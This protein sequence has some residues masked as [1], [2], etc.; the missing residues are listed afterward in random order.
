MKLLMMA[1]FLS[2]FAVSGNARAELVE[3]ANGIKID[4]TRLDESV[5]NPS[6]VLTK[7][8][9]YSNEEFS[10]DVPVGGQLNTRMFLTDSPIFGFS[11]GKT[12]LKKKGM[13]PAKVEGQFSF[14]LGLKIRNFQTETPFE[15]SVPEINQKLTSV[16]LVNQSIAPQSPAGTISYDF[17]VPNL[18][19]LSKVKKFS[20]SSL[21]LSQPKSPLKAKYIKAMTLSQGTSFI[22]C[23]GE[24]RLVNGPSYYEVVFDQKG[25]AIKYG[26]TTYCKNPSDFSEV[27]AEISAYLVEGFDAN[28]YTGVTPEGKSCNAY[29]S[30]KRGLMNFSIYNNPNGDVDF[31]VEDD[32]EVADYDISNKGFFITAFH[33]ASS[34]RGDFGTYL[35]GVK[36]KYTK[37]G[38]IYV[39]N[40]LEITEKGAT[41][42]RTTICQ[43]MH[44]T[45]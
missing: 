15:I 22:D 3:I 1:L 18:I 5:E 26:N 41:K 6:W 45:L 21:T 10:I 19:H 27:S 44:P 25:S 40:S 23:K 39:L 34:G 12:Y 29:A 36:A 30:L 24:T 11:G 38:G 8:F 42:T 32:E 13:K 9:H 20:T 17:K 14:F 28:F 4:G 35:I 43:S 16:W 7:A 37:T 2:S 33:Q 31:E